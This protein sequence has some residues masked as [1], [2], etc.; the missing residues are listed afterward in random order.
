MPGRGCCGTIR[1]MRWPT[2]G[3]RCGFAPR[4]IR[5]GSFGKN[6]RGSGKTLGDL[7]QEVFAAEAE[8]QQVGNTDLDG[9]CGSTAGKEEVDG[10]V[11]PLGVFQDGLSAGS[12]RGNG[13][14]VRFSPPSSAHGDAHDAFSGMQGRG[15][16]NGDPFGAQAGGRCGV[17]LVVARA[18]LPVRRLPPPESPNRGRRRFPGRG[19]QLAEAR[20]PRLG[21]PVR[22]GSRYRKR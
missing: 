12:A 7:S 17:F 16:V 3:A 19:R 2:C 5:G 22:W 10:A 21:G 1:G 14:Q 9:R 8:R 6:G 4:T 18:D 15:M 11:L 20:V 13:L